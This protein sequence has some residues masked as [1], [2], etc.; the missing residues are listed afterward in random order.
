MKT[1]PR[2][3]LLAA[4]ASVFLFGCSKD[5]SDSSSTSPSKTQLLTGHNW[6]LT[7]ATLNGVDYFSSLDAC[8]IDNVLNFR[9]DNTYLM[10][11]GAALCDT[12]APQ[13]TT[14]PWAFANNET[15]LV[16]DGGTADEQ[17]FQIV[18]LSSTT[19]SLGISDSLFSIVM[20]YSKP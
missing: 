17:S 1:F 13:T 16:V 8:E 11:E 6:V 2:V 7:G 10:D 20:I 12:T 3:L 4:V 9:T 18:T 5:D 19:L 15:T 14:G